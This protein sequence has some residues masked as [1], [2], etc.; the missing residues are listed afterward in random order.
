[1]ILADTSTQ[2]ARRARA[3][4]RGDHSLCRAQRCG[5]ARAHEKG[6]HS[7]C[8][9]AWCEAAAQASLTEDQAVP[10]GAE[11]A[12]P[13]AA[14]DGYRVRSS[15]IE[16]AGGGE[17]GPAGQQ[18]WDAVNPN[19]EL[20]PLPT[21]LLREAC[22]IADR[23]QALDRHLHGDGPWLEMSTD[24]GGVVFHVDVTE[25]LK[26][27]RAQANTFRGLAVELRQSATGARA[28]QAPAASGADEGEGANVVDFFAAV[29][30]KLGGAPA[31]G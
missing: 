13:P 15:L 28:G 3:H 12:P 17:F 5:V 26:E 27:A 7:R 30:A 22:R 19:G 25:V 11:P 2:R 14:A 10:V 16:D 20:K 23:L 8:S 1:M 21:V 4:A 18:L 24:D 29:A 9:A 6:E 31:E